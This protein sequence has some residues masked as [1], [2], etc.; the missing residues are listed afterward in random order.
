MNAGNNYDQNYIE[1]NYLVVGLVVEEQIADDTDMVRVPGYNCNKAVRNKDMDT[2]TGK[3]GMGTGGT[4]AVETAG[5]VV[6]MV[7]FVVVVDT[8]D[9]QV[10]GMVD[11]M[12]VVG[13]VDLRVVGIH[14]YMDKV[15]YY[16][17]NCPLNQTN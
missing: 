17:Y 16:N 4:V 14:N 7:D 10:V 2:S 6:G 13:M 9:L 3:A 12:V 8:V 5:W 11:L 1:M 15:S